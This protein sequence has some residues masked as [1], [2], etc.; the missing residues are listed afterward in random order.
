[1]CVTC[2]E[3]TP[4]MFLLVLFSFEL[5]FPMF[6][7]LK[8]ALIYM[9]FGQVRTGRACTLSSA[10][11]CQ[12]NPYLWTF[13]RFLQDHHLNEMPIFRHVSPLAGFT[14]SHPSACIASLGHLK[15]CALAMQRHQKLLRPV[16]PLGALQ[17][18]IA[19][20][21]RWCLKFKRA[22]F[23]SISILSRAHTHTHARICHCEGRCNSIWTQPFVVCGLEKPGMSNLN[24]ANRGG[25]AMYGLCPMFL[26]YIRLGYVRKLICPKPTFQP[27]GFLM[28]QTLQLVD[29][30]LFGK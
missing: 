12:G 18:E 16:R 4:F 2:W 25:R 14:A 29:F 26:L 24:R 9:F 8:V 3:L 5:W 10:C 17:P 15:T 6:G 11:T 7:N 23:K 1:M 28:L 20:H 13:V 22:P 19:L 21:I 27:F 30:C